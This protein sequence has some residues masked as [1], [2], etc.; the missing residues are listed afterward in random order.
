VWLVS[1]DGTVS[2]VK[3]QGEWEVVAVNA[4]GDEVYATP[5][6]ADGRLYIRT[7]GM[8]YCFGK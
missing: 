3:A 1:Q 6:V 2:V 7:R 4:L 8:L 5:A